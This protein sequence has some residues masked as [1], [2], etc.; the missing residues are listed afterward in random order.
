MMY[1]AGGLCPLATTSCTTQRP[2]VRR[3][4]HGS[5]NC[6]RRCVWLRELQKTVEKGMVFRTRRTDADGLVQKFGRIRK[7]GA[8]HAGRTCGGWDAGRLSGAAILKQAWLWV[9]LSIRVNR[10]IYYMLDYH[11]S[12]RLASS[13]VISSCSDC[14]RSSLVGMMASGGCFPFG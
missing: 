8:A 4:G 7:V 6:T 14:L 2:Q 5:C 13:S 1:T 3:R 12:T 9:R 10:R 11:V